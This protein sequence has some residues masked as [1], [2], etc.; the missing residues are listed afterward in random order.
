MCREEHFDHERHAATLSTL[1][2]DWKK[3]QAG[4]PHVKLSHRPTFVKLIESSTE[5]PWLWGKGRSEA[6]L[7]DV[8]ADAGKFK[9]EVRIGG[10]RRILA[11]ATPLAHTRRGWTPHPAELLPRENGQ[12]NEESKQ[13]SGCEASEGEVP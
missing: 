1:E 13:L 3:L 10:P 11:N 5:T 6:R 2:E 12:R 7:T 9:K 4:A 8:L